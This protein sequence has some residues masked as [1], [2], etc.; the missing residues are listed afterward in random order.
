MK[1]RDKY[2]FTGVA[3]LLVALVF[4]AGCGTDQA[5]APMA[6][7]TAVTTPPL[8]SR[9]LLA[10]SASGPPQ[11]A[12]K[13]ASEGLPPLVGIDADWFGPVND[14]KELRVD[15]WNGTGT[16]DDM[17]VTFAVPD[18]ALTESVPIIM[19]V[20]GTRLT[21]ALAAFYPAG[22]VFLQDAQVAFILGPELVDIPLSE[23]EAWHIHDDGSAEEAE[24][25]SLDVAPNGRVRIVLG[26]PGF[27]RY[28]LGDYGPECGF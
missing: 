15:G 14:G 26:V 17:T 28:C 23:L 4:A 19:A 16:E 13:I 20:Y 5:P 27:S 24:I 6:Q 8:E 18:G 2:L 11:A 9:M 1:I 21:E 7:D 12:A 25:V 3:V 22:L 10:F